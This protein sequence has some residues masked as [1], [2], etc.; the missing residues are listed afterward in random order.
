[1]IPIKKTS[2]SFLCPTV[3]LILQEVQLLIPLF[4]FFQLYFV[5][6]RNSEVYNSARSLFFLFLITLM[7][8]CLIDIIIIIIK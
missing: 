4:T 2:T 8:G 3:F 5:V 1:M 6:S 7:S